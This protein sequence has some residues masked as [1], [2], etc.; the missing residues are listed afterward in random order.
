[1]DVIATLGQLA[2]QD[3]ESDQAKDGKPGDGKQKCPKC[4]ASAGKLKVRPKSDGK[5]GKVKGKGIVTCTVCGFQAEVDIVPKK[6]QISQS[7]DPG[8]D[9][10]PRTLTATVRAV[11][12]VGRA[13]RVRRGAAAGRGRERR[14]T[15]KGTTRTARAAGRTGTRRTGTRRTGRAAAGRT[16]TRMTTAKGRVRMVTIPRTPT[17]IVTGMMTGRVRLVTPMGTVPMLVARTVLSATPGMGIP[18]GLLLRGH[19]RVLGRGATATA[20][21]RSAGRIWRMRL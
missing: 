2:K 15:K 12:V 11:R 6:P 5:G 13:R 14:G 4:G 21:V 19:R 10:M 8:D 16:A 18:L 3:E 17:V 9:E 20:W 1:M 7:L